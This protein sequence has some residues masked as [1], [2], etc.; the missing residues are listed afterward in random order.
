MRRISTGWGLAGVID[1]GWSAFPIQVSG[2][3]DLIHAVGCGVRVPFLRF[4][5]RPFF[6]ADISRRIGYLGG[7]KWEPMPIQRDGLHMGQESARPLLRE[8]TAHESDR[9]ESSSD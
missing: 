4:R 7:Q 8:R 5:G 3:V 1:L 9:S 2:G 6:F